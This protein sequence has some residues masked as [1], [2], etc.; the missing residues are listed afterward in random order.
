M[1]DLDIVSLTRKIYI[2]FSFTMHYIATENS[3]RFVV[4]HYNMARLDIN[5]YIHQIFIQMLYT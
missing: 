3:L 5:M 2:F 1:A 4:I